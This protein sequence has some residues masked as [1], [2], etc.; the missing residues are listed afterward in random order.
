VTVLD[1]ILQ[2]WRFAKVLPHIRPGDRIIDVGCG[3]AAL[4]RFA[5]AL[6]EY[7]GIDPEAP[8]SQDAGLL[9]LI[10]GEVPGTRPPGGNFDAIVMLA[11]LEHFPDDQMPKLARW[12]NGLLRLGGALLI[13]VPSPRVD[14]VLDVLALLR[15]VDTHAMKPEE[16]HGF[17]PATAPSLFVQNGF[18]LVRH[19]H[20]QLGLNNFFMF[21]KIAEAP[22]DRA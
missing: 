18:E 9:R 6:G 7:V 22:D 19:E 8:D 16:H 1:R 4:A 14:A 3:D 17:D 13:T 5:P 11:A 2:R 21:R 20:F 15:L 10:R 12:S